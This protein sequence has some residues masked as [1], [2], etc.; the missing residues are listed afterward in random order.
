MEDR[1]SNWCGTVMWVKGTL[2]DIFS[3]DRKF[4][5]LQFKD[6]KIFQELNC[7]LAPTFKKILKVEAW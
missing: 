3:Q 2:M 4:K 6:L 7:P 5:K 1:V